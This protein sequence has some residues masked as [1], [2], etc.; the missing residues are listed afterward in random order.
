MVRLSLTETLTLKEIT[1]VGRVVVLVTV[2]VSFIV[3]GLA[4]VVTDV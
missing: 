4:V 2:F 1:V 3:V